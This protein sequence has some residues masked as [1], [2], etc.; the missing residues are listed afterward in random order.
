MGDN[1]RRKVL[2]MFKKL[3]RTRMTIFKNDENALKVVRAKINEEY[4][5]YKNVQ[6]TAAIEELIKFAEEVEHEVR[7]TVI[8]AVETEPGKFALRITP[9]TQLI[10]NIPYKDEQSNSNTSSK[11]DTKA[12][13]SKDKKNK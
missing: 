7:T 2:H 10:D 12:S 6:N 5:K 8:Q 4:K 11:Q 3:H 1:L 13:V 9:D